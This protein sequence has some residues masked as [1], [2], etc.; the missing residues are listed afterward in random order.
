M[1]ILLSNLITLLMNL[2]SQ[3]FLFINCNVYVRFTFGFKS[4]VGPQIT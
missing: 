3:M 2:H 4:F 1:Q